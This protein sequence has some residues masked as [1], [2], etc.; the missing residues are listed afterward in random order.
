MNYAKAHQVSIALVV[1]S[2]GAIILCQASPPAAPP[3]RS[4]AQVTHLT[5]DV[6]KQLDAEIEKEMQDRNLPSVAVSIVVPGEAPYNSAKGAANLATDGKRQLDDPFRIAS[7]TKTFV[8]LAILQLV[9]QGALN[10]TD[11]ISKWFPDFPNAGKITV[12]DLLRMRSGIPDPFDHAW[13]AKYFASPLMVQTAVESIRLAAA[14]KSDFKA[15]GK[16]TVYTNVNF[17]LLQVVAEKVSGKPIGDLISDGIAKPL[18]LTSTLWPANNTLPGELRGYSWNAATKKFEDKTILNPQA[19]GGA[20]AMI[21]D[22]TD[23]RT[24]VRALCTGRF[25]KGTK[26]ATSQNA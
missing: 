8:G 21:S 16:E 2:L 15:P 17:I 3:Q 23:L 4:P 25:L 18:G 10:K 6:R 22:I 11:P 13:L 20:G 1:T 9:D 26:N 7:N 24:Y 19:P 14:R 12:D 5:P